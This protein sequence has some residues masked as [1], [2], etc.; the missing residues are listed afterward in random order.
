[1]GKKYNISINIFTNK[2]V[3]APS[4]LTFK[5]L[6]NLKIHIYSQ[7]LFILPLKGLSGCGRRLVK[8][9]KS[10]RI[11]LNTIL[12]GKLIY[13]NKNRKTIN[14]FFFLFRFMFSCEFDS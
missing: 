12:T 5:T 7:P 3:F 1:M 14:N 2:H 13:D 11:L 8:V 9:G 10:L 4:S 6:F